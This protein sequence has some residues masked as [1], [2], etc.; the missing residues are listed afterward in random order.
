V[1]R[2]VG[3]GQTVREGDK[4]IVQGRGQ[5][6]RFMQV[7]YVLDPDGTTFVIHAMPMTARKR[8]RKK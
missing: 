8:R 5:G 6:A 3:R 1:V 2:N 7:I 4:L